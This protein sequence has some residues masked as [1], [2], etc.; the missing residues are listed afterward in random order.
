MS[1]FPMPWDFALIL[2]VLA[3]VVPW[4]G[5]VKVRQLLARPSLGTSDRLTLYATTIA[6][7]WVITA[8]IIWR[9][10]ARGI[11]LDALGLAIPHAAQVAGVSAGLSAL[12]VANQIIGLRILA[13]SNT[14][15]KSFVFQMATR[16]MPQNL[17]ESLAFTALVATVALCEEIIYRGFALAVF[18]HAAR[19][20]VVLG[21]VLSSILFAV[22]HAYQG[23]RGVIQTLVVGLVF[24]ALR[25]WT[26]SLVPTMA[27]HLC[28]DLVA[29]LAAPRF[30]S[31]QSSLP[32]REPDVEEHVEPPK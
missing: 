1:S 29:G 7:Q 6:F 3:V 9:S 5:A 31:R 4:R 23:R 15:P 28:A 26:R 22:A 16:I 12:L 11:S 14:R 27:A 13:R 2:L 25:I 32:E 17:V 8:L 20:S 19:D 18:T 24:A 10:L 21:V 30:F